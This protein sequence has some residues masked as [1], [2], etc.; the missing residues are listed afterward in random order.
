MSI[1]RIELKRA[2]SSY[3]FYFS[4]IIG[5]LISLFH[6]I[7]VIIPLNRDLDSFI[8]QNSPMSY[9]GWLFSDWLGGRLYSVFSYLY[10]MILPLLASL[11]HGDS[12]FT[13]VKKGVISN[14]CIRTGKKDYYFAKYLSTFLSGGI[15]VIIPLLLNF[16][17]SALLLPS[18][19]PEVA[20]WNTTVNEK[21]AFPNIYFTH[22]LIYILIYIFI[23][24]IFSG[25]FGTLSL[26]CSYYVNYHFLVIIS[27]FICY[28]FLIAF[29][30]LIG[31]E[32]FQ[33]NNFLHPAYGENGL[34]GLVIETFLLF[35]ITW[36]GFAHKGGK[37]DIY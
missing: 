18:M 36:F 7:F 11:P 23:I 10:F 31:I 1:L 13:D 22:P 28:I 33:P 21:S 16:L 19:K 32:T 37:E 27:P 35:L 29:F 24:F 9:P 26:V 3:G 4:L 25:F 6:I 5:A 12:F 14:I 30:G 8:L 20:F 15:V 17:L 34:P 2:F